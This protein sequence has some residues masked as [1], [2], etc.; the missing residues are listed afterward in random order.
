[1]MAVAREGKRAGQRVSEQTQRLVDK[2]AA[3]VLRKC[4]KKAV[5]LLEIHRSS[6]DTLALALLERDT[7]T[8]EDILQILPD[9]AA[10]KHHADRM[11]IATACEPA[12][13]EAGKQG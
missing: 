12:E 10:L 3:R 6:L 2:A 4:Y 7:L 8:R 1:M 5:D 11:P 13:T 9:M